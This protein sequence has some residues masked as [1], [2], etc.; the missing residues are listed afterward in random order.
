MRFHVVAGLLTVLAGAA[1]YVQYRETT[2]TEPARGYTTL[3]ITLGIA[4]SI[5]FVCAAL[6]SLR[7][8]WGQEWLPGRLQ[9]WLRVHVW[10]S[11]L[12]TWAIL[13]HAGFHLDD[14][15]G[16][17]TLALLAV[18][19]LSGVA[20]WWLY[21]QMPGQVAGVGN[22]AIEWS[23]SRIEA[24]EAELENLAAGAS[25][26][27]RAKLRGTKGIG[28][29]PEHELPLVARADELKAEIAELGS[30][31]VHQRRIHNWLRGWIWIHVPAA[32]VFLIAIPVHIFD[33]LDW[34]YDLRKPTPHDFASP[35]SC[36]P[37]HQ[38]QYDEWLH[39]MHAMAMSAPTVDLQNQ[40]VMAKEARDV[41]NGADPIVGDLCVRCHAPT[42]SQPFLDEVEGPRTKLE[43][44][45]PAS[46]FGIS[47]VTCHQISALHP[48]NPKT[49]RFV[50]HKGGEPI[51]FRN[52]DNFEWTPGRVMHGHF[53]KEGELPSVGNANHEGIYNPIF[54]SADLC[55]SCHTVTVD[56]PKADFQL[57]LQDTYREWQDGGDKKKTGIN[58][59]DEQVR[60]MH[61]HAK[62]LDPLNE[63]LDDLRKRGPLSLTEQRAAI[64]GLVKKH[65]VD[66]P[67][68]EHAAHPADGFDLPLPRRRRFR[69]EFV[70]VDTPLDT[71]APFPPGHARH[72]ENPGIRQ[73]MIESTAKLMRAA[74]SVRI[75]GI[76]GN[77]LV[78]E[79]LNLATGHHLPAG[80]A[81]AREL[82]LEVGTRRGSSGVLRVHLGG[83]NGRPLR[84]Q[85]RLDKR[86]EGPRG[87]K[88]FQAVLWNGGRGDKDGVDGLPEGET[89]IQ[90]EVKKVLKGKEA[91]D[92]G[93]LDRV[94]FLLPGEIRT[95]KIPVSSLR[96]F[97]R[98]DEVQVR[99]RFRN[100]P[101][102]FLTA[103]AA[104]VARELPDADHARGRRLVKGLHIHE[105]AQ[106]TWR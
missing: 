39:S 93:F 90:N 98:G 6:Y 10:I 96:G 13:L 83:R 25:D 54:E 37:C 7:K 72:G 102:E 51:F 59:A 74:A 15:W 24:A 69:H 71:D 58:W 38:V 27:L 28:R 101:P 2:T 35:E 68:D 29:I 66:R 104:R 4:A 52:S 36:L 32:I 78:V 50:A 81:F 41:A 63:A 18:T 49:D 67:L 56:V 31:L 48:S 88:N 95:L 76:E 5:L 44:R 19:V 45:A 79:V 43:D 85:E 65:V 33:A 8:R 91:R 26:A 82:W 60:C 21:C 1:L 53:G 62:D 57:K 99:L 100:Y 89:V 23:T 92:H 64:V 70:G 9:T 11:V 61:C 46:H 97:R 20:G 34:K 73:R 75:R 105:V 86:G 77:Q 80:F 14:T 3:G 42:G 106:D 87:L 40:L 16:V 94:N 84:P 47:C 30:R 12:A 22:L 17:I 103:L 55:A